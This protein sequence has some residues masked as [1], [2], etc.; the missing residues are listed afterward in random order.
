[1]TAGAI[2]LVCTLILSYPLLVHPSRASFLYIW[3]AFICVPPEDGIIVDGA[4]IDTD[5]ESEPNSNVSS[6]TSTPNTKRSQSRLQTPESSLT[7]IVEEEDGLG[8]QAAKSET[9]ANNNNYDDNTATSSTTVSG[10][11][12]RRGDKDVLDNSLDYSL[13]SPVGP[14][15]DEVTCVLLVLFAPFLSRSI[16]TPML[17]AVVC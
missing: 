16:Q 14:G 10:Q 9:H 4:D 1:M 17:V 7:T 5:T 13:R 11:Y 15:D 6:A 8:G 3:F 12:I 2:G